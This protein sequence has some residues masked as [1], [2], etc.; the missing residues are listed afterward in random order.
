MH[1]RN[2]FPNNALSLKQQNLGIEILKNCRNELYRLFPYLDGAFASVVY[3]GSDQ[4]D[5]IG[6]EGNSFYFSPYFLLDA[7]RKSPAAVRRGYLHMLLHCLYLHILPDRK[8][9]DSYWNL[10][11]DM[12]VEQ[13]ISKENQTSLEQDFFSQTD[14]KL[15]SKAHIRQ[16][17]LKELGSSI[18][19]AEEIYHMLITKQFSCTFEEMEQAFQFDD[20]SFWKENLAP[21]KALG[22]RRKW[23]K[24]R[25]YASQNH[26]GLSQSAGTAKGMEEEEITV[27]HKSRYDY[28]SFL[29]RF[30]FPREEVEL[31]TESFDYISYTY[32]MEYYGNL[33]FIE[34][35]EYKEGNKL[36]ELVIAIDT[37]GS[38]SVETVQQF[39]AETYSIFQEKENFFKKMKV[40]LIQCDCCIQ[41]VAVIHSKEEW[42]E[43]SKN[44][45]IHG[46]AGTDFRPVF[47]YI[48]E[49]KKQKEL[50]N[51]KALIYFTDGD[52]IYPTSGPDYETA[53]VFLKK[54]KGMEFVPAWGIRLI[55]DLSE[56][57][58]ES[59]PGMEFPD[60]H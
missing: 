59:V 19:S 60:G 44:V 7:Y 36:E 2:N 20:H 11:C 38:C 57:S 12:S 32:G 1:N 30:A 28:R 9:Q 49:L 42:D 58:A 37:S 13:I 50:R 29:K 8:Y 10:A 39:L 5:R 31:D 16:V 51:L 56:T 24:I 54:T 4:T 26:H 21:K 43:Y 47:R 46:R 22:V 52:G 53:F 14:R 6:T 15:S 3:Q 40:F 41:D 55:A 35:L 27:P 45:K 48:E 17:C 18:L 34:P 33:P 23:E 25:S